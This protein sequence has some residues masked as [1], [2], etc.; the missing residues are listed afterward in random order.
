MHFGRHDC[1]F[2]K[3]FDMFDNQIVCAHQVCVAH[4]VLGLRFLL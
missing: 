4:L 3:H 2:Q 1:F